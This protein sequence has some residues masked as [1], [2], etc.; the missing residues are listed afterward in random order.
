MKFDGTVEGPQTV[1]FGQG[2]QLRAA[3]EAHAKIKRKDFGLKFNGVAEGTLHYI[4]AFARELSLT[5]MNKS[6]VSA[7][8]MP[9]AG[10]LQDSTAS[11]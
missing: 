7:S 4:T 8:V 11:P 1:N 10:R 6:T 9:V 5:P 3:Y 2:P